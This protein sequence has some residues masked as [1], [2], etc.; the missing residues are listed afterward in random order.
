M[1]LPVLDTFVAASFGSLDGYVPV[2]CD[3]LPA[4]AFWVAQSRAWNV[5]VAD[6]S[7]GAKDAALLLLV[8]VVLA[9]P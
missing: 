2:P 4:S 7:G 1:V 9:A 5:C 3:P 8:L 6:S